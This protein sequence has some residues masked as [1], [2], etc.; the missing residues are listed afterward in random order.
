MFRVLATDCRVVLVEK[1]APDLNIVSKHCP[2]AIST[3]AS[4]S[5][6]GNR[7]RGL[8]SAF[9]INNDQYHQYLLHSVKAWK[10]RHMGLKSA[11][12]INND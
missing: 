12:S 9:S 2:A 5:K 1:G 10:H 6:P 11:F 8:K 3:C 4:R 7:H